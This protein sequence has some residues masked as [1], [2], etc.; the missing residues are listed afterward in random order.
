MQRKGRDR[1]AGGRPG[2][3]TGLGPGADFPASY[4]TSH[5]ETLYVMLSAAKNLSGE[6]AE[7]LDEA[8]RRSA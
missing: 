4:L 1:E 5:H 7:I 8:A 2:L 6:A 3:D